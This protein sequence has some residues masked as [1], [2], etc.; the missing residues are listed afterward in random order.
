VP[1]REHFDIEIMVAASLAEPS[2]EELT[3]KFPSLYVPSVVIHLAEI[4]TNVPQRLARE[5]VGEMG[6]R[7]MRGECVPVVS[8]CATTMHLDD[9]DGGTN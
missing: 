9:H 7:F 8:L 4:V 5:D 6:P 3:V 1:R 2:F